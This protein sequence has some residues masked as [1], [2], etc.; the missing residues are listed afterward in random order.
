MNLARSR[1][2]RLDPAG[3]RLPLIALIDVVLFL[4]F[5]F[6]IAGNIDAEEA[7]LASTLAIARGSGSAS[8]LESQLLW[9]EA[10]DGQ[11]V[12]RIGG[13]EFADRGGLLELL[14]KLPKDPGVVV[15]AA[16]QVELQNIATAIQ[17]VKDAG[18]EK[19]TYVPGS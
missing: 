3:L 10:K 18:F 15:R 11:P 13:R 14:K 9:I 4:L 19:I 2:T 8:F 7:E 6:I 12:Y 16:D 17:V 1:S 5:Y